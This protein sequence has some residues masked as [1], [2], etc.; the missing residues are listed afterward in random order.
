MPLQFLW[1]DKI[2]LDAFISSKIFTFGTY[3]VQWSQETPL[4]LLAPSLQEFDTTQQHDLSHILKGWTEICKSSSSADA[5]ILL[6]VNAEPYIH[7]WV[8]L[9][10]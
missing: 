4:A 9:L 8:L 5:K 1:H 7:K 6:A 10:S 2:Y 3:L